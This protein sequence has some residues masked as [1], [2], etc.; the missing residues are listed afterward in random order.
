VIYAQ[1][2]D[3]IRNQFNVTFNKMQE[4]NLYPKKKENRVLHEGHAKETFTVNRMKEIFY[5]LCV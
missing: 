3:G 4:S 5:D 1:N 2:K